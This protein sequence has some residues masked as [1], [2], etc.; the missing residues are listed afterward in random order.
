MQLLKPFN[1]CEIGMCFVT[2]GGLTGSYVL[3]AGRQSGLAVTLCESLFF[4]I[5]QDTPS[6]FHPTNHF[7]S[8]QGGTVCLA[9][10]PSGIIMKVT[11]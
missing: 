4:L 9:L 8:T 10:T 2:C 5:R 3:L 7:R 1:F 11:A 6:A